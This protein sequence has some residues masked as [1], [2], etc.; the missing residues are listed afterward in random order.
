[1]SDNG[2]NYAPSFRAARLYRKTSDKGNTYFTG[3][4]GGA[5][6]SLLKSRDVA[7]DGGEIWDLMLAEAPAPRQQQQTPA[8]D[9]AKRQAQRPIEQPTTQRRSEQSEPRGSLDDAI[10]F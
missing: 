10:P 5:R 8:S 7:E 9:E 1:M 6:V 4:W 2:K 3:R